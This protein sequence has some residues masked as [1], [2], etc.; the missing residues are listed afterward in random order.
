MTSLLELNR[1]AMPQHLQELL[2]GRHP[3]IAV[4]RGEAGWPT[5]QLPSPAT[6]ERVHLNSMIDPWREAEAW[7]DSLA[8]GQSRIG[9]V[10]GCGFGYPLLAYMKRMPTEHQLFVFERDAALFL[11]MLSAIDVRALFGDRRV[12]WL[13]GEP[14]ALKRQLAA[15]MGGDF[16]VR[17]AMMNTAF[18]PWAHRNDRSFYLSLHESLHGLLG[19]MLRSGGNS[20]HDTLVGLY[21]TVANAPAIAQAASLTSVKDA[22]KGRP[23]F[24]VGNGPSLDGNAEHLLRAQGKALI[25]TAE[26]A[27]QPCLRR[28]IIPDAVCVTERTP[29][30]YHIHFRDRELPQELAV[31]GL[32]LVDP[33]VPPLFGRR[34][35]PIFRSVE[36]SG[37][38]V[39][40]ALGERSALNGGS[41]SAHLA[42]ELAL[43]AGADPIV[44]VGMDLAF[45]KDKA[46]H[47]R[48]SDYADGPLTEQVK[49]LQAEETLMVPGVHGQPVA[50]TRLWQEFRLWLEHQISLYPGRRFIDA[51]EGGARIEGTSLAGLEE[52]VGRWCKTAAGPRLAARLAA[53]APPE[54]A[55][56]EGAPPGAGATQEVLQ[57]ELAAICQQLQTWHSRAADD[58]RSCR[59]IREACRLHSCY[60]G[61]ALPAFVG[62]LAARMDRAYIGYTT[63]E[64]LS[65]YLNPI[66]YAFQKRTVELGAIDTLAQL[67]RLAAVQEE[68]FSYLQRLCG[69]LHEQFDALAVKA[70]TAG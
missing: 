46:T 33:R 47:S 37:R 51:T 42:F 29:Q 40:R 50:T 68:M 53:A 31:A 20:V 45:G 44:F 9:F 41:S 61:L 36:T 66:I 67:E 26:S 25:L 64:Q 70:V 6:G 34:W 14:E 15:Y 4:V 16:L 48:L 54:G 60:E 23:A 19:L 57:Q 24:I 22:Y 69:A 21:N 56:P 13:I 49:Q 62:E 52:T 32:T 11:A 7:A 58:K 35:L 55:P 3:E 17:C 30:V 8:L 5:A 27:L 12:H 18:T 59:V 38:W 65:I 39:Q 2:P 63:D 10:Y 28:G 1:A 43:W